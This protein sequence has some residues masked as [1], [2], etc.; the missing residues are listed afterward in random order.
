MKKYILISLAAL[1]ALAL[2]CTPEPTLSVS[3]TTISVSADAGSN[4][5][6]VSANNAWSA[7]SS[8]GW[9]HISTASG[10]AGEGRMSF[11]YDANT[12]SDER[13]ATITVFSSSL[14]QTVTVTQAQCD[15][16]IVTASDQNFGPEGGSFSIKV[17]SNVSYSVEIVG[18]GDWV[19]HSSTKGLTDHTETFTVSENDTYDARS[20]EVVI[21]GAGQKSSFKI[22]QEQKNA[23]F[24]DGD[25]EYHMGWKGGTFM[26]NAKSNIGCKAVI[27]LGEDWITR[28][29]TKGLEEYEFAFAVSENGGKS[30]REGRIEFRNNEGK[31]AASVTV[32][33]NS[34]P[35]IKINPESITF[36]KEGGTE[37][38]SITSNAD[39]TVEITSGDDWLTAAP[40]EDGSGYVFTAPENSAKSNRFASVKI[41]SVEDDT[42]FFEVPV[43]QRGAEQ[44]LQFNFEGKEL[45]LPAFTG[46]GITG[47]VEWGD[48]RTSSYPT[49]KHIYQKSGKYTVKVTFSGGMGVKFTGVTGIDEI[50]ISSF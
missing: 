37:K 38:I 35:Y 33:Q 24:I 43:M 49:G 21:S 7:K 16:V 36:E 12:S 9:I 3:P 20:C 14:S 17:Q 46:S 27:V 26:V 19:Q 31:T 25:D 41:T 42:V 4:S 5:I 11:T 8:D 34:K 40:D 13:Q 6:N 39:Y 28:V 15:K 44:V 22:T 45:V 48:N 10:E 50:D 29:D 18:G 32:F 30:V 1:A 2:S 47:T 23:M